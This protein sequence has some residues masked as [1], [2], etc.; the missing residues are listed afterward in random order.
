[1]SQ[2]KQILE[3]LQAGNKIT[4]ID[5]LNLFGCFRLGA[6]ICDLRN[7]GYNIDNEAKTGSFAVYKLKNM[8][9]N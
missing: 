6:R 5:A 8:K 4:P 1:M 2:E 9:G 3:Y 7:K